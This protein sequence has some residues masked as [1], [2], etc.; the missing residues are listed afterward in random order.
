M[1]VQK[2]KTMTDELKEE[3]SSDIEL[4]KNMTSIT[5]PEMVLELANRL[6]YYYDLV[7]QAIADSDYKTAQLKGKQKILE[8]YIRTSKQFATSLSINRSQSQKKY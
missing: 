2:A 6:I 4:A 8:N 3:M 7:N 1:L 5:S